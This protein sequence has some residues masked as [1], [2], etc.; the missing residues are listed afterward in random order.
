MSKKRRD[1]RSPTAKT[2]GGALSKKSK[3]STG[4]DP[5]T[6]FERA[7]KPVLKAAPPRTARAAPR[8]TKAQPPSGRLDLVD[9]ARGFAITMMIAYH[10]CFDLTYF[11]WAGW[12]MLDDPAWIAW[13]NTIVTAFLFLV[14]VSLALRDDRERRNG[15]GWFA[16]AFVSRWSQIAGAAVLVTA[17]SSMLFPDRF[18]Y[19]GVLHFVAIALWLCRRAPRRPVLALAL[20]GIALVAGATLADANFDPRYV[21]W[22]GFA[23]GKPPTEDYVPL[24]PW[25]GVTLIGCGLGGLWTRRGMRLAPR[26]AGIGN[27]LP[28]ALRRTWAVMGRFSLTIYLVHQPL[29]MGAMELIGKLS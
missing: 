27:A 18:I 21:D 11:G 24:F 8:A 15:E 9:A 19:F 3:K 1:P 14:G 5:Q 4:A 25:L 17:G 29:L 12:R 26:I 10:F 22:I 6:A 16:R 7:L 23:T 28:P 20:G 2:G 13:R